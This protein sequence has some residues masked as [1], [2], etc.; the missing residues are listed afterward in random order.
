[1]IV[2]LAGSDWSACINSSGRSNA[3]ERLNRLRELFYVDG[4][5]SARAT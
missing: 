1:M 2:S 5:S 4:E 3:I